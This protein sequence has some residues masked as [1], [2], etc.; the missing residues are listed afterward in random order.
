MKC[1]IDKLIEHFGSSNKAAKALG[2]D[3]QVTD[4]WVKQGY[5]PFKRGE[6][7]EKATNGLITAHEVY[8]SA[9]RTNSNGGHRE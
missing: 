2:V 8:D 9:A 6:Q 1:A 7:I 3:R 4:I 5:I